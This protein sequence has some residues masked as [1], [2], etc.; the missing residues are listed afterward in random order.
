MNKPL[1]FAASMFSVV[2]P[3]CGN[4]MRRDDRICTQCNAFNSEVAVT[5]RGQSGE[6]D[7]SAPSDLEDGQPVRLTTGVV[8]PDGCQ[9]YVARWSPPP[10]PLM[11]RTLSVKTALLGA[12][13]VGLIASGLTYLRFGTSS[14]EVKPDGEMRSIG[15]ADFDAN[16]DMPADVA[17]MTPKAL[18]EIDARLGVANSV[19]DLS[20]EAASP[21]TEPTQAA[22]VPDIQPDVPRDSASGASARNSA[23]NPPL[24]PGQPANT[25]LPADGSSAVVQHPPLRSIGRKRWGADNYSPMKSAGM[26]VATAATMAPAVASASLPSN[27]ASTAPSAPQHAAADA[28]TEAVTRTPTPKQPPWV[29][30]EITQKEEPAAATA[31]A[32]PQGQATAL[33]VFSDSSDPDALE[34]T[35]RQY[36]WK[37]EPGV[38]ES[39]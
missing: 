6:Q 26:A 8:P 18:R 13:A 9:R 11:E 14:V 25:A 36:G 1:S 15:R 27:A 22:L 10:P 32:V 38:P 29:T 5:D 33:P 20:P 16:S 24:S 3:R 4:Q 23:T 39:Q 35:I 19:S 21:E 2:C 34:R 31:T 28:T 12:C 30:S 37:P 17:Y 7:S